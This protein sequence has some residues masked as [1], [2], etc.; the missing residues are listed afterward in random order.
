MPIIIPLLLAA[1]CQA[2]LRPLFTAIA[3]VESGGDPN[4]YNETER[5][6]GLYQLR[7]I[8]VQDVNRIVGEARF[9]LA[10][11]WDQAKAESM[12]RIY[13]QHYCGDGAT[14]EQMA[15]IHNGGPKGPEKRETEKY[16][17]KVKKV[18]DSRK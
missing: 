15:R 10:D 7:P 11:R 2:S 4:A 17:Q 18:L 9:S 3:Q 8:Y 14:W 1:G 13:W 5:A 16:W 12:M 6:A